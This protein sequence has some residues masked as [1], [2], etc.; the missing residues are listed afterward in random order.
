MTKLVEVKPNAVTIFDPS[1]S[2]EKIVKIQAAIE[3]AKKLQNWE[4]GRAAAEAL[5][6]EQADFVAWWRAT[7]TTNSGAGRGKK[8]PQNAGG[9]LRADVENA[10]GIKNQQV[11]RWAR[12]LKDV[13]AYKDAIY[14]AAYRRAMKAA[15]TIA[16]KWTGDNEGYTPSGEIDLVRKAL[17][18]IDLDPATSSVAQKTV[19]AERCFTKEDDALKQSWAGNVFLNPPYSQPE[20]NHFVAKLCAEVRS[21]AVPRAILLTNNNTDTKWWHEAASV[22]TAICFT[23]GRINFYKGDGTV[24][25]PT[26]GQTFFYFGDGVDEFQ[27]LFAARGLVLRIER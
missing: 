19:Q 3:A 27:R 8:G 21:G 6:K 17:G 5:V 16:S 13:E 11:S 22:A 14:G 24:S 25:Q 10:T 23:L 20:I 2:R 15:D 26:N 12:D 7:V 9:F 1:Q 4:A 18:K